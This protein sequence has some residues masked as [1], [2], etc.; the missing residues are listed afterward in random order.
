MARHGRA[1]Q[2]V[3]SDP[4]R[5]ISLGV[6]HCD[7]H[8]G[9]L[10]RTTDGKLC[11]LDWGMTLGVPQDLQYS[12]IEFIAHVNAEDYAAMPDDF[13][14]LG[15]T[16]PEQLERVRA[17]NLTEGL[18][19]VLR[20][21]SQGGGGK[22]LQARVRDEWREQY[23]PGGLLSKEELRAKVREGFYAQARTQL[24][25]DGVEGASVMDVQNVMEKMQQRNREMFRVPPYILYVARAFSTLEGIG[26]SAN[27][28]YSIVSEAFP[29]LSRRLLTDDSPR[30][31]AALRSMLYGSE[32]LDS[33]NAAPSFT[34]VSPNPDRASLTR[35]LAF[36]P[37]P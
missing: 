15:F 16:P 9:N 32:G 26:L 11:I 23:D 24:E 19:F 1:P 34:Q 4:S 2:R 10:L 6:L 30:A 21:L 20:Q 31:K 22:K 3:I 37:P 8:P 29:Y 28:D 5:A 25:A 17:S 33:S 12:L 13:V 14:R 36:P 35:S 27:E 7:P 18:S